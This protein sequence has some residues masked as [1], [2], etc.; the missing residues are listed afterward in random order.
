MDAFQ[1]RYARNGQKLIHA[2]VAHSISKMVHFK[3]EMI[4]P[5][6]PTTTHPPLVCFCLCRRSAAVHNCTHRSEWSFQYSSAYI[7][8]ITIMHQRHDTSNF[9]RST[10]RNFVHAAESP[11]SSLMQNYCERLKCP[12]LSLLSS[13]A[14]KITIIISGLLVVGVVA[15]CRCF[16]RYRKYVECQFA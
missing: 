16:C 3:I 11:S 4:S 5:H 13:S 10:W 9:A 7:Y 8:R 6:R 12:I 1:F 2:V 14:I 15:A